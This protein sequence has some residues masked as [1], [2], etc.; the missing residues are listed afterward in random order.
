MNLQ[1]QQQ[2]LIPLTSKK[3]FNMK[4]LKKLRDLYNDK[5]IDSKGREFFAEKV[6]WMLDDIIESIESLEITVFL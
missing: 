4:E 6:M 5:K 1:K 2:T 3:Q